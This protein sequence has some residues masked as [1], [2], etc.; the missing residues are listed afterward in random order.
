MK[1]NIRLDENNH[2]EVPLPMRNKD[3]KLRHNR[4]LVLKRTLPLQRKFEKN[5]EFHEHCKQF[6]Q[7]VVDKGFAQ[8]C[9][10]PVEGVEDKGWYIPHHGVYHPRKPGKIRVVF[11]CSATFEG[12]SLNTEVPQGPDMTN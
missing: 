9:Q 6:M 10:E 5:P 11:D 1:E 4:E 12:R 2:Y 7:N 3:A 8:K